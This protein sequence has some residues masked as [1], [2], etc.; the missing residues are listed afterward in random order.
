MKSRIRSKVVILRCESYDSEQVFNT[1][2]KGLILL[3]G[4]ERFIDKNDKVLI[5]PNL[6][7]GGDP[8]QLI[9]PH[10]SVFE[11]IIK[12]L[13]NHRYNIF[14]GDS[15]G[16][17]SPEKVA[18]QAGLKK[19]ADKYGLKFGEFKKGEI[20]H[21]PEGQICKQFPIAQ[22]VL[23]ADSILSLCKMKS[24]I[25]TRITGAV[26]NQLGCVYGL[27]KSAFHGIFPDVFSFSKMLVDLSMYLKP[28]LYIMDGI[29][30]M[31]GNGPASGNPSSMNVILIS[32]DPV[33]LDATFCRIINLK[34]EY[35]PYIVYGKEY[36]LGNWCKDEI[37][38]LGDPLN[39][40]INRDFDISRKPVKNE[41]VTSHIWL[42]KLLRKLVLRKSV[43]D[44]DKCTKCGICVATCPAERGALNFSD[45]D[46][47]RSLIFDYGKCIRCFCCQEMC[48]EKAIDVKTPLIGRILLY[49]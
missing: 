5:K 48:P 33:A 42:L 47:C 35:I 23:E 34:P 19:I 13:S 25:F 12:I 30:A 10:P 41:T 4:I 8:E 24:H 2:N 36:G 44:H 7:S 40:F 11:G 9:S 15:P 27:H 38:F 37:D 14:Y 46:K 21:F 43:I 49:R 39:S 45:D 1:L 28:K 20:V 29:I 16:F 3:G 6:L 22:A 26:K 18:R 32:D 31:E 17:G